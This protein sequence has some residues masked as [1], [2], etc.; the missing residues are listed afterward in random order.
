MSWHSQSLCNL[1]SLFYGLIILR[2]GNLSRIQHLLYLLLRVA[3]IH[4]PELL[5]FLDELIIHHRLPPS[6]CQKTL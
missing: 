1:V 3:V 2:L 6:F 5:K 4:L